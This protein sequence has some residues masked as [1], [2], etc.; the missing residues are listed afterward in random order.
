M[1]NYRNQNWIRFVLFF[2]GNRKRGKNMADFMIRFLI[3]NLLLCGIIGI[4]LLMK[5]IL[6]NS[7]SSR[8]QYNLWF[9]LLGLLAVPFLPFRFFKLSEMFVWFKSLNLVPTSKTETT[10]G[11]TFHTNIADTQNWMEDFT[12]SISRETSS[13]IGHLLLALWISGIIAM[14]TLVI[15]SALRLHILKKSAL[16]LQSHKVQR[17]YQRCLSDTGITKSV[18]IYSTAYLKS[19]VIVGFW[20]PC[21]YLPIHLI[22]DDNETDIRY[23]LLLSLI[24]I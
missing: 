9:L 18:P 4:F 23:M 14:L 3:C 17:I 8:M 16:P 20:K 13:V 6:K 2:R 10:I 11:Q 7:L 22:A 12:L 19:P 21:I 5:H 24:H 15:R 1:T